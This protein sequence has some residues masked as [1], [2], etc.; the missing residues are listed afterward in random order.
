ME[1]LQNGIKN[2]VI[3]EENPFEDDLSD[4]VPVLEESKKY[5]NCHR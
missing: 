1:T 3:E 5:H 2:F 4:E